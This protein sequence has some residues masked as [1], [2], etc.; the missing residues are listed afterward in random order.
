MELTPPNLVNVP[1]TLAAELEKDVVRRLMMAQYVE[2]YFKLILADVGDRKVGVR[3]ALCAAEKT[4]IKIPSWDGSNREIE[5]TTM[6]DIIKNGGEYGGNSVLV[7]RTGVEDELGNSE[8]DMTEDYLRMATENAIKSGDKNIFPVLLV[9]DM[10]KAEHEEGTYKITFP[11]V[12]TKR[13]S[14]WRI[15]PL[16]IDGLRS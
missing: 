5:V 3:A 8:V 4:G 14:L 9:Y 12:E 7:S 11:D 6:E 16:D 2:D 13:D 15:Y 10:S 1:E